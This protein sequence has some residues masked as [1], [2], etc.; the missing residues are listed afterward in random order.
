LALM[1]GRTRPTTVAGEET[2]GGSP[3]MRPAARSGS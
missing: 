1:S 2:G 3:E